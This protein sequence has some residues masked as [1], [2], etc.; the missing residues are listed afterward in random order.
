MRKGFDERGW[1]PAQLEQALAD[2]REQLEEVKA[3]LQC[4][5]KDAEGAPIVEDTG[6]YKFAFD[7]WCTLPDEIRDIEAI[8]ADQAD[9]VLRQQIQELTYECEVLRAELSQAK[10]A[11]RAHGVSD[12]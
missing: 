5:V 6:M 2:R 10:Q 7:K 12:G 1:T 11:L 8:L 9:D 4:D 3:V